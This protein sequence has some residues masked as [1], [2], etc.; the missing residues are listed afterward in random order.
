MSN[1]YYWEKLLNTCLILLTFSKLVG[2]R[3]LSE[4]KFEE[5]ALVLKSKKVQGIFGVAFIL[6]VLSVAAF[7][8]QNRVSDFF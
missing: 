7:R 1:I 2:K 4:R 8:L 5:N 6:A 3:N